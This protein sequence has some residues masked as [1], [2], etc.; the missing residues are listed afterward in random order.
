MGTP[1]PTYY[2]RD[3]LW[4]EQTGNDQDNSA[5]QAILLGAKYLNQASVKRHI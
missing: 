5:H 1:W 4:E 2:Q 3:T